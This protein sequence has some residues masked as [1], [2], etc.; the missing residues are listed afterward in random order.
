M[1]NP[2]LGIPIG[3]IKCKVWPKT[4][5]EG[6]QG[7]HWV[8]WGSRSNSGPHFPRKYAE[9]LQFYMVWEPLGI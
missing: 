1:Q 8:P 6:A 2:G 4:I 3:A 9:I 5:L 7:S